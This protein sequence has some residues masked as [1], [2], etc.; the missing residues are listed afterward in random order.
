MKSSC[1][2]VLRLGSPIVLAVQRHLF[3]LAVLVVQRLLVLRLHGHLIA[4][5]HRECVLEQLISFSAWWR[6]VCERMAIWGLRL[7]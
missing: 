1:G 2:L 5:G 7:F 6:E 4:V 3:G